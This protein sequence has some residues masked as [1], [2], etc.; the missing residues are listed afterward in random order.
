MLCVLEVLSLV[1]GIMT[2]VRGRFAWGKHKEVRGAPAYVI[3]VVLLA[4]IPVAVVVAIVLNFDDIM[5]GNGP[6][7]FQLGQMNWRTVLPDV[8][9]VFGCWGT[10]LVIAAVKA[11]PK[12][13]VRRRLAD[14]EYDDYDDEPRRRRR[15]DSD[16]YDDEDDIPRRRRRADPEDYEDDRPPRGR[17]GDGDRRRRPKDDL[18]DRAR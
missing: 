6:Q 5:K 12:R 7:P 15:R 13:R 16:D 4:T 17:T 8:I 18:D 3:G 14:D 9:A 1:Y 2:L 10:A 11:E